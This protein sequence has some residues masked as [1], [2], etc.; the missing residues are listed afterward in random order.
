[1]REVKTT[2]LT[3]SKKSRESGKAG[4]EWNNR[5]FI[6]DHINYQGFRPLFDPHIVPS[7]VL[8]EVS[9]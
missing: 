9:P 4:S 1:M 5:Q 3:F 2:R 6:I 8:H 7:L